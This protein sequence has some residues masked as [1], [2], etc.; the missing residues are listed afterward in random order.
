MNIQKKLL[1][2]TAA[3]ISLQASLT[4]QNKR[5]ISGTVIDAGTKEPLPYVT[6]TLKKQLI[7]VVAN[8]EGNFD[9][10][11][12]ESVTDDTLL[13]NYLGYK[14]VLLPMSSI[15]AQLSIKLESTV[16]QLEEIVI[17]PLSPETY[18]R[19]AMR[20]IGQNYPDQPFQTDAYYREKVLENKNLIRCDE[21]VFKTYYTSYAD[22]LL[23]LHQL[24]LFRRAENT[25]KVAFMNKEEKKK[26]AKDTAKKV[27]LDAGESFGGPDDILKSGN[28]SKKSENFL[29]STM[30]RSYKYSFA[31]SS[32]YNTSELMVIDFA[33]KGK[34]EH[35][36]ESGRIYIDVSSLAIVKIECRGDFIIPAVIRPVLFFLSIGIKNPTYVKQSEFQQVDGKWYPK[37][38]QNEISITLTNNHLFKKDERSDFE[39][40]QFF[41]V[42]ALKTENPVKIPADKRF[43]EGLDMQKQ[44]YNDEGLTW[45]GLNII[46]K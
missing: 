16:V 3:I 14:H 43:K 17:R 9:L 46:K 1:V 35:K 21:G 26:T 30:F 37:S 44:V 27:Q 29:D 18:I 24:L 28:L 42:N 5:L 11:V 38:I 45:E 34:V 19:Y 40:E 10:Y 22:T 8:E 33:S 13:V 41:T 2:A 20:K 15:N 32:S 7:G 39:I 25:V 23:P 12:P 36:R 6:L 31:K 4:S